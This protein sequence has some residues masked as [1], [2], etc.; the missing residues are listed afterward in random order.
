[1]YTEWI[2]IYMETRNCLLY[3]WAVEFFQLGHFLVDSVE[4]EA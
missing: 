3:C 2:Y 4:K 1:M